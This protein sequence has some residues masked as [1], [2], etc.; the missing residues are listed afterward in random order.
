MVDNNLPIEDFSSLPPSDLDQYFNHLDATFDQQAV[1]LSHLDKPPTLDEVESAHRFEVTLPGESS[2][3]SSWVYSAALKKVF[4]KM[5]SPFTI[6]VNYQNPEL[7]PTP[8][9]LY[10]R[11]I[12][13][14]TEPEDH[15]VPVNRCKHHSSATDNHIL[16]CKNNT[17]KFEGEPTETDYGKRLCVVMPLCSKAPE[18]LENVTLEFYCQN[19]CPSGINRRATALIFVLETERREIVGKRLMYFKVCSCPKRDKQKEEE[20]VEQQRN[21]IAQ[22]KRR[23]DNQL[24]PG[25]GKRPCKIIKKTVEIKQ[26]FPTPSQTPNNF[27]QMPE[28]PTPDTISFT[29][30]VANHDALLRVLQSAADIHSVMA[31]E[32]ND[33]ISSQH[34]L[35]CRKNL[36]RDKE[37]MEQLMQMQQQQQQYEP[38]S[39]NFMQ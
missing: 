25:N 19:S 36:L 35:K 5:N 28:E 15:H 8:G 31:V 32:S 22:P 26:E 12:P 30:N 17:A 6:T 1:D 39:H 16:A 9:N 3:K 14:F 13:V 4:I 38:E 27:A 33:S 24:T 37:M 29:L 7:N 34:F 23:A 10:L 2:G 20:S 21:G 18:V 11:V